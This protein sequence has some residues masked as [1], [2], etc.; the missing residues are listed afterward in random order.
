MC[1]SATGHRSGSRERR[2]PVPL[3]PHVRDRRCPT[4]PPSRRRCPA[5]MS[6]S[7][8]SWTSAP[9]GAD[10]VPGSLDQVRALAAVGPSRRCSAAGGRP[11]VRGTPGLRCL[12]GAQRHGR[13]AVAASGRIGTQLARLEA[14]LDRGRWSSSPPSRKRSTPPWWPSRT[15]GGRSNGIGWAWPGR[16]R[17]HAGRIAGPLD[18]WW[19]I[20]VALASLDRLEVRGR[21]SAG[22]HVLVAGHG[23]DLAGPSVRALLGAGADPLF[24]SGAV[25]R[26]RLPQLRVQGGGRDRRARRQRQGLRAAI[27]GDVLLARALAAPDARATVVGHTRWASVGLIS[28][29]NA[30]PLNSEEVG[31][32]VG[33]T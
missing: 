32:P 25:R 29:P 8:P 22:L 4:T 17:P 1:T 27:R 3:T 33:P 31:G 18:G 6:G 14:E 15:P 23:L 30:H 24:G 19:A 10:L 26:R 7:S 2:R 9:A 5:A 13:R 16:R 21:D 28:E 12:L 20:Q 11:P